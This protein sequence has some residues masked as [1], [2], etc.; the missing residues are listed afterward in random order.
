[1]TL[2]LGDCTY[3]SS[4]SFVRLIDNGSGSPSLGLFPLFPFASCPNDDINSCA[5]PKPNRA[6]QF[7]N[8]SV[9]ASPGFF[10]IQ[11][12]NG[13]QSEMT[14]AE[15]TALFRFTFPDTNGGSPLILLDLTDL[16]NSRQDNA[17]ISIDAT[18]GRMTG[19]S[20]FRP[21]F[22]GGTYQAYFCADFQ[23]SDVRD[24]GIFVDYVAS[25]DVKDVTI[26]RGINQY[27]LPAGAFVR[28]SSGDPITARVGISFVSSEQACQLAESELPEFGF[29]ETR[30]SAEEIWRNKMSSISVDAA[31]VDDSLL[32]NFYSGIY[33]TMINP[34]NYTG[35]VPVVDADT[36]YFDSFYW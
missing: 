20:R 28:F 21:S 9:K 4:S 7:V 30:S 3:V 22:G 36:V 25:T 14:A 2:G 23:G 6:Q 19:G 32:E 33:R 26:S 34:Q 10:G 24:N 27:P 8:D 16:S 1:M 15:H 35:V 17:T 5:F 12:Q 11:L 29:D 18:T 13:I 31:G